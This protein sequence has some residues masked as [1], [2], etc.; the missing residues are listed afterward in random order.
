MRSSEHTADFSAHVDRKFPEL[1]KH[2][3]TLQLDIAN[4]YRHILR[5]TTCAIL[6]H[7][8]GKHFEPG[9]ISGQDLEDLYGWSNETQAF[10]DFISHSWRASRWDKYLWLTVIY[11]ARPATWCSLVAGLV[12][13]VLFILEILPE[14][15]RIMHSTAK[16]E[17]RFAPWVFLIGMIVFIVVLLKWQCVVRLLAKLGFKQREVFF[18]RICI[19]Q[20]DEELKKLG[21]RAIGGFLANSRRMV[22][23]WSPEY[24]T[25]L[26]CVYEIS[27]FNYISE[28]NPAKLNDK[29]VDMHFVPLSL[30]KPL[31]ILFAFLGFCYFLWVVILS[32]LTVNKFF[33]GVATLSLVVVGLALA[34]VPFF[35]AW[36][37][38]LQILK[39]H[40]DERCQMQDQLANFSV[41]DAQCFAESDREMVKK[42]IMKMFGNDHS[43]EDPKGIE[44]F[45]RTVQQEFKDTILDMLGDGQYFQYN[46]MLLAVWPSFLG[47]LNFNVCFVRDLSLE[48]IFC[49]IACSIAWFASFIPAMVSF[50][51]FLADHISTWRTPVKVMIFFSQ[52]F[53]IIANSTLWK[54]SV[55]KWYFTVV[56]IACW[57]AGFFGTVGRMRRP[58]SLHKTKSMLESVRSS[59]AHCYD[60]DTE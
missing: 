49:E 26:W 56:L 34:M 53:F 18:D 2:V 45:D 41:N 33:E 8:F 3:S 21:I 24:L 11:N 35:I 22:I 17:F 59:A 28:H 14:T 39:R 48:I 37:R 42:S 30:A 60:M 20:K 5:S 23:L 40:I 52:I 54:L 44:V 4:A 25:R 15:T 7:G 32:S 47:H 58:K 13:A 29:K 6:L 57:L 1:L 19:S 55:P 10:D 36:S 9:I 46:Y 51:W 31:A 16:A 50:Q 12:T 38:I 27:V 43:E